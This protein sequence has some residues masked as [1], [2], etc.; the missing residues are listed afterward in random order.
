VTHIKVLAVDTLADFSAENSSLEALAVLLQAGALLAV[1]ALG[2]A[3]SAVRRVADAL[4]V[5]V[6]LCGLAQQ[7]Q[8]NQ[9]TIRSEASIG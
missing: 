9:Q 5:R 2:V 8:A 3:H 7:Q 6:T 4:R 1:A